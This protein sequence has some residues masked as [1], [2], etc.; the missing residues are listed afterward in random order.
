M[1][2]ARIISVTPEARSIFRAWRAGHVCPLIRLAFLQNLF[3][4]FV[5]SCFCTVS[6]LFLCT[7]YLSRFVCKYV[8]LQLIWLCGHFFFAVNPDVEKTS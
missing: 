3:L 4:H 5:I 1:L 8:C 6:P 2:L 7:Y